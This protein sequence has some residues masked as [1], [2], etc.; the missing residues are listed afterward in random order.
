MKA[1]ILQH[2][3]FEDGGTIVEIL[4]DRSFE[5][6][7]TRFDMGEKPPPIETLN[8]IDL[9]VIMGGFMSANDE[10]KYDWLKPE[11]ELIKRAIDS[12][13]KTLGI[14]LG[15]QLIAASLGAKVYPNA[16]KEI[17]WHKVTAA[18]L[19]PA[20]QDLPPS[21]RGDQTFAQNH[22]ATAPDNSS[23]S[24]VDR[25]AFLPHETLAF[26]WHGETFDLPRGAKLVASS[27]ACKNQ[28]FTIGRHVIA[29]QF[30]L[31][32]TPNGAKLLVE[33]C[34]DELIDAPYIQN[35]SEILNAPS[36]NYA[37]LKRVMTAALDYLLA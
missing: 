14:C 33:N 34:C 7:V 35:E 12:G 23:L 6:D 2:I 20:D 9:L 17:G 11:K 28:A 25:A 3:W 32:T 5:I 37:A 26:H 16:Q 18:P 19:S 21:D 15:A 22:N 31:E 30:H 13:V 24:P 29:L 1:R 8:A 4:R 36:E 10:D 27:A